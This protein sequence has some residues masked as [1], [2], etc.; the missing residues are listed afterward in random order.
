MAKKARDTKAEYR[1]RNARAQALGYR[2]YAHQRKMRTAGTPLPNDTAARP[3]R[4]QVT[5]LP[6]GRRIIS[7]PTSTR[8]LRSLGAAVRNAPDDQD[9]SVTIRF[10]A[11][12]GPQEIE[13]SKSARDWAKLFDAHGGDIYE[14]IAD[15]VIGDLYTRGGTSWVAGNVTDVSTVV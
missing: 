13:V 14:A 6:D 5:P 9:V 12:Q 3:D 2:S 10:D 1:A 4:R 7:T 11:A 8:D 15:G